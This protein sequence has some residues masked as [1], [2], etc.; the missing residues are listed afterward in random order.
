MWLFL[1]AAVYGAG[2]SFS[3]SKWCNYA[4]L[5]VKAFKGISCCDNEASLANMVID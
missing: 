5:Y 4:E 2:K 3:L 1:M